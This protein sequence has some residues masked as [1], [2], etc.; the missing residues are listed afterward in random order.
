LL[1]NE[2]GK[3]DEL[4]ENKQ[5]DAVSFRAALEKVLEEG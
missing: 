3:S 1:K 5:Y 4:K 2:R